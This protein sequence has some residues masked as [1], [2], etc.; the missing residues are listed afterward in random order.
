M[1]KPRN[2][3]PRIGG[4][5]QVNG[6]QAPGDGRGMSPTNQVPSPPPPPKPADSNPSAQ[7]PKAEK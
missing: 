5:G 2:R 3:A 7:P 4:G 6:G 1:S